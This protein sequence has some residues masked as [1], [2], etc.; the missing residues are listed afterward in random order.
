MKALISKIWNTPEL[1]IV[2]KHSVF[3]AVTT[4]F[5]LAIRY[6]LLAFEGAHTIEIAQR[7]FSFEITDNGAYMAYYISSVVLLYLL[8]WWF[9]DA[10]RFR[11][12]VSGMLAFFALYFVSMLV[13]N[14]LLNLL[15]ERW[16]IN[17]ELAFW[18][19]CSAT[20]VFNFLGERAILFCDSR[21]RESNKVKDKNVLTEGGAA[22]G[23][24]ESG[25]NKNDSAE[26]KGIS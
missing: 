9:A 23:G 24:E 25:A 6:I 11:N 16:G 22:N 12:F 7:A 4:L 8:K 26:Q 17:S 1:R 2:L 14:A 10:V 21:N 20:F 3:A 5:G 19:I 13:G 15:T 18:L